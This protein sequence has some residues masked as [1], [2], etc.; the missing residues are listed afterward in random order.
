MTQGLVVTYRD[1]WSTIR[2]QHHIVGLF[3]DV[4]KGGVNDY[5]Q[6]TVT[7]IKLTGTTSGIITIQPFIQIPTF[8]LKYPT[9]IAADRIVYYGQQRWAIG[10]LNDKPTLEHDFGDSVANTR[11][12]NVEVDELTN[13]NEDPL[14]NFQQISKAATGF[15]ADLGYMEIS[16][17]LRSARFL[18][19]GG[20]IPLIS[21]VQGSSA[22]AI[23]E[24]TRKR[25]LE[26]EKITAIDRIKRLTMPVSDT[27]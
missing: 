15:V 25:T 10:T 18:G 6:L 19:L 4:L 1:V 7:H 3:P 11:L 13:H 21:D 8:L 12:I 22:A 20:I 27:H 17:I 23:E 26:C 14:I 9:S 16:F 2:L 5:I 24:K